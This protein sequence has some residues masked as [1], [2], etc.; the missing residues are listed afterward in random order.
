MS[1]QLG[2][3]QSPSVFFPPFFLKGLLSVPFPKIFTSALSVSEIKD[4]AK[5]ISQRR[6]PSAFGYDFYKLEQQEAFVVEQLGT[7]SVYSPARCPTCKHALKSEWHSFSL[8]AVR[9]WSTQQMKKTSACQVCVL[10]CGLFPRGS[11]WRLW[12]AA[13]NYRL[14]AL[15]PQKMALPS[16]TVILMLTAGR[17]VQL[18]EERLSMVSSWVQHVLPVDHF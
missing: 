7:G 9:R 10:E 11:N 15:S 18:S 12:G 13:G 4:K 6:H 14:P 16:K 5:M 3:T 17:R 2:F 8:K 1:I